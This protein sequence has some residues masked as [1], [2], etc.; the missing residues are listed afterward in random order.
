[1]ASQPPTK[2]PLTSTETALAILLPAHLSSDITS[3]RLIHDK[4]ASKWPA[5][6]NILYPFIPTLFLSHAI[7]LLQTHLSSLPF[8]SLHINLN[9]VG[10][11]KHRK[12]ATVFLRPDEESEGAL[13]RLRRGLTGVI[14]CEEGEGT[15]EGV[16]RPHLG[17]G[18]A[19]MLGGRRGNERGIGREVERLSEL[20]RKIVAGGGLEWDVKGLVVLRREVGGEMSVLEELRF[21][22]EDEGDEESGCVK[23]DTGWMSCFVFDPAA[24]YWSRLSKGIKHQDVRTM[25]HVSISSYN[26]MA[27]P[28]A[29]HFNSRLPLIISALS[30]PTPPPSNTLQILTLQEVNDESLPLILS[31]PYIRKI[32]PYSTHAPSSLLP[33]ARNLVTL[34]SEPFTS[35]VVPFEERH[36]SSLVLSFEF[37]PGSGSGSEKKSLVVAN[38]HLTSGLTDKA[39]KAKKE[40]ME[41]LTVFLFPKG[42]SENGREVVVAGD[43]NLTTSVRTIETALSRGLITDATAQAV[44]KIIDLGVWEDAFLSPGSESVPENETGMVGYDGQETFEGE[45]GATFDRATNPIAAMLEPPIDRSP[46]R[47][48]RVL[49]RKGGSIAKDG[50]EIFGLPNEEGRCG[51]DHYGVRATLNIA[52]TGNSMSDIPRKFDTSSVADKITI[53][54]D[55]TDLTPLIEPY[56]PSPEDIS[57]RAQAIELL[58]DTLSNGDGMEGIILAPLGSYLMGTYFADSDVD[59]LAIGS[60][61]PGVFFEFAGRELRKLDSGDGD[62]ESFKGVH[63]VNS[64]VSIVEVCVLGIKFDLQYSQAEELVRAYHDETSSPSLPDLVFD[65]A[66]ISTLSPSSIRPLNTY[67]DSAYLL[68]TIPH[69]QSY[70]LAHRYLTLYLKNHGLYSAKFG[71]LGGIHLQLMLNRVVKLIS[72]ST[73]TTST[74]TD[75]ESPP[76]SPATIVRTFFTYYATFN[77]AIENV[78]DPLLD[79]Q[80]KVPRSARDAIFIPA[81]HTPT[82]RPNVASS[83]TKLTAHTLS[84][85]FSLAAQ[86]L[87]KGDCGSGAFVR[88]GIDVWG[89]GSEIAES[90]VREMI[91]AL[92]SRFP[93][94]MVA[95]GRIAGVEGRAWPARLWVPDVSENEKGKGME[96][97]GGEEGEEG[98]FKGYYIVGVSAREGME[99]ETKQVMEGK[100]VTAVREFERGV[101]EAREFVEGSRN[102]WVVVDVVRRKQVNGMNLVL[103]WR[104]WSLEKL[105]NCVS[106]QHGGLLEALDLG[107]EVAGSPGN[108][109]FA[110]TSSA[111]PASTSTTK[112]NKPTKAPKAPKAPKATPLRPAHEI[113]AR[114]KWD[115]DLDIADYMIGYEDRFVGVKEME[116][117]KWKSESTDEEFIPMH[118]VVWIR[119]KDG[120]ILWDRRRKIDGFFGSGI[121]AG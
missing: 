34:A 13:V 17:V 6:I 56:L 35:T 33:S 66:L 47:Y 108:S 23:D 121:C 53:I 111:H 43:F 46:Q 80:S 76:V 106:K 62:E 44:R 94:L 37:G 119:L 92:E 8:S 57:Q 49:F 88:V 38:V 16:F 100:L 32:Y 86:H 90:K 21:G 109:S 77:W 65:K 26:I 75:Q 95:L 83:C 30:S 40:Q 64:L 114:I 89:V 9:D 39:F 74:N 85:Q 96:R 31:S 25:D 82:A 2:F 102:V 4:S 71:Y 29:E 3:I 15:V 79:P 51:S 118:R 113:I 68:L 120:D 73:L 61:N 99:R 107:M 48:D 45:R 11:F 10:V 91:G 50:F 42:K 1:M 116:L 19:G 12:N 70:R 59:V 98:Q 52:Q 81:I 97:E 112:S 84:S 103:D 58:H 110:P 104:E 14:G 115:P 7:P 72:V 67:R 41:K 24:D 28:T 63:F 117:E 5:H 78:T 101:L 27:E 60:V 18:Q 105:Q 54:D 55:P 22:D 20:V 36:K 87:A 69:L 93:R